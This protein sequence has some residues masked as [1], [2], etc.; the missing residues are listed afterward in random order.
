MILGVQGRRA[1]PVH[2]LVIGRI[3]INAVADSL[4]PNH[5]LITESLDSFVD[6]HGYAGIIA[7]QAVGDAPA[8]PV[9]HSIGTDH[10]SEGDVVSI[11]PRGYVRT[12]YRRHSNHNSLF[13]TDHCNSLCLMCSQPP[14]DVDETG[15][16]EQHLRLISLIDPETRELGITGGE[17]TLLKDGLL[18][19]IRAC[20]EQ[21]PNTALH[22]LSNGRLF[23]YERFAKALA[24]LQ[25]P[26]LMV[27]IP[28]YSPIDAEHDYVVQSRGAFDQ[29]LRGLQNLGRFGVPV[30]IRVVIHKTTYARLPELAQFIYRNLTFASHVAL[31]GLEMTGFTIPNS[32]LLWIDPWDYRAELEAA[33]L[34]LADRG[35][36]VS[37]Y[38][39]QLCTL[40]RSIWPYTR[41]SISDWKNQYLPVCEECG[42]REQCGGF[43]ASGVLRRY[44]THI[45]P[46]QQ[47]DRPGAHELHQSS[48]AD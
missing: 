23:C 46:F 17:P 2:D 40:P 10:L 20:K 34:F 3:T 14:R 11:G 29:T 13:A 44:S 33:T 5:V 21:L 28:V 9:V 24:D 42:A 7:H 4:R 18:E 38:N 45:E 35:M 37:I 27:G 47:P 48:S 25:H 19:V 41:R 31:M 1:G 30:E 39:H 6:P 36:N 32:E 16:I 15:I 8:V 43:F 26:D 12:L 22:M